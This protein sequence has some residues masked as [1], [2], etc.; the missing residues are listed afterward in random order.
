MIFSSFAY[1]VHMVIT[2]YLLKFAD[3]WRVFFF[4]RMGIFIALIPVFFRFLP[5]IRSIINKYGKKVFVVIAANEM[6]GLAGNFFFIVAASIGYVT[7][8]NALSSLR[9]FFVF[10]IALILSFFYPHIIKE[11]KERKIIYLK[12]TAIVFM[13][14][15]F[16]L[17]T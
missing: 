12:L 17:M 16:L 6:L 5:E 15:G 2:K 13:V 4:I 8:V 7:L 9:T 11:E 10:F 1:A 14:T 3:Y